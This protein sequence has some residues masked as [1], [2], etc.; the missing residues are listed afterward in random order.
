MV[1]SLTRGD[2]KINFPLGNVSGFAS[3]NRYYLG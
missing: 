3:N 2:K 1:S